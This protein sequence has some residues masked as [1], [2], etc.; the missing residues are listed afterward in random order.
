MQTTKIISSLLVLAVIAGGG[1]KVWQYKY[2]QPLAEASAKDGRKP[3]AGGKPGMHGEGN[4]PVPVLAVP[5][6]KGDLRV[7]QTAIGTVIPSAVVTVRSRVN[8]QLVRVLFKEGQSVR[9]GELLAEIDPRPFQAQLTQVQGQALH[10]QALLKNS[11]LDLERYKTLQG[12]DSIATQQV[13]AQAS[14]VQQNQGT[15]QADQGLVDNAKLQVSFTRI[16]A[17]ISGRIGLR[18]IDVGNNITTA[19]ALAVV[20]TIDPIQVVFTLPEDRVSNIVRR[21][22]DARKFGGLP[23]EAWDKGNATLLAKGVLQSLDNQIDTT[24]GTIKLK[25]QL[26]NSEG[27]LFP[28][29]FVNIRLLSDTL[30]DVTVVPTAAIQHGSAG[31]FVYLITKDERKAGYKDA[32]DKGAGEQPPNNQAAVDKATLDKGPAEKVIV[33]PVKTGAAD[34][35]L[36]AIENGLQ[37]GDRVVISGIDKLR[38]GAKVIVS[39]PDGRGGPEGRQGR[40]GT[41]KGDNTSGSRP[42]TN[43]ANPIAD[44]ATVDGTPRPRHGNRPDTPVRDGTV[45]DGAEI[46]RG[47]RPDQTTLPNDEAIK[48]DSS[49]KQ[50]TGT[51]TDAGNQHHRHGNW[52]GRQGDGTNPRPEGGWKHRSSDQTES[53]SSSAL[54]SSQ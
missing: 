27:L 47:S 12:Q 26:S 42:E 8:G 19:D 9:A 5:V 46:N 50:Q 1:W 37:P 32:S 15:V 23:V 14:L 45:T 48:A 3:G 43:E 4:R 41:R 35:D 40:R 10:N 7:V 6:R 39:K 31:A 13:D 52:A 44:R 51:E 25:A 24:S 30:H 49:T 21:L 16:T 11:Q 28:N 2:K 33:Q 38:D 17:P 36:V 18:Q 54:Q 20:N 29:Q 34:G 22:Q 53:A